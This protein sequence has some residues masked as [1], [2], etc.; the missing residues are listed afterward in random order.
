MQFRPRKKHLIVEFCIPQS[1]EVTALIEQSGI[2]ELS[3]NTRWGRYRIQVD[4]KADLNKHRALV[5]DLIRR[6]SGTPAPS[7]D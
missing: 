6:S 2:E 4:G 7:E 5:A 1:D 3:Y